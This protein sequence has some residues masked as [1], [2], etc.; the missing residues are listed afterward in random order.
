MGARALRARAERRSTIS[1]GF[2]PSVIDHE[3][4]ERR[5]IAKVDPPFA[6]RP[7]ENVR[8]MLRGYVHLFDASGVRRTSLTL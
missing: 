4:G 7:D 3:G 5:I 8:L 2:R 1:L 6:G